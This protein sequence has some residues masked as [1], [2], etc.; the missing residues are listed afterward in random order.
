MVVSDLTCVYWI[1]ELPCEPSPVD[2][3]CKG[4]FSKFLF[5]KRGEGQ[6]ITSKGANKRKTRHKR[7]PPKPKGPH[8]LWS[9]RRKPDHYKDPR[10]GGGPPPPLPPAIT[11]E[12]RPTAA[13]A[14]AAPGEARP[15]GPLVP[16][17][18]PAPKPQHHR[19]RAGHNS[20][21]LAL[22]T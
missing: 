2:F 7:N 11:T 21:R 14:A 1:S 18:T 8:Q 13:G 16:V 17:T 12:T 20:T 4:V 6:F 3:G 19:G 10:P 15:A 9:H 22:Q 5:E